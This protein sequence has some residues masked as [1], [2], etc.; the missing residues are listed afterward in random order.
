MRNNSLTG[1]QKAAILFLTLGEEVASEVL[2]NLG[3]KE[4]QK[5]TGFMRGMKKITPEE[6]QLVMNEFYQRTSSGDISLQGDEDYIKRIIARAIGEKR[7]EEMLKEI[8]AAYMEENPPFFQSLRGI[9]AKTLVPLISNEHP[10]VIALILA[11]LPSERA[12]QVLS[13]LP[14]KL[15]PEVMLKISQTESIPPEVM[16]AIDDVLQKKVERIG[17]KESQKIGGIQRV[18]DVLNQMDTT[19]QEAILNELEVKNSSLVEEIKQLMFT[20]EDLVLIDG[21]GIQTLL[22]EINNQELALALKT[23]NEEIKNLFFK[24]MSERAAEMLREDME[25]MGP[26]RLRDVEA[27]QRNIVKIA[28]KL[29]Q[30]GKLVISKRGEEDVLV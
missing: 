15:R 13:L 29:E 30:E 17:G 28:R 10:Q 16:E 8:S 18:A 1:P 24:N 2:K 6:V 5:I 26:V 21:R 4:I 11:H 22:K 14:E 3:D 7:A 20:F 25:V 19:S 27:A 12:A 9:D 23:A